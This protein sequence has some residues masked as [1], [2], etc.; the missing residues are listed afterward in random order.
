MPEAAMNEDHGP[1]FR[2]DNI[3]RTGKIAAMEPESIA[4]H[5]KSVADR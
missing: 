1:E 2:E 4:G 5:V 3:R